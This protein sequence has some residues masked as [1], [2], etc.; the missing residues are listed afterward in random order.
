MTAT[1]EDE[2]EHSSYTFKQVVLEGPDNYNDWYRGITN[3]LLIRDLIDIAEGTEL[4]PLPEKGK[5]DDAAHL[6]RLKSFRKDDR[7]AYGLINASVST[8]VIRSVPSSIATYDPIGAIGWSHVLLAHLTS[9]YSSGNGPRQAEL[10]QLVF[11][12]ELDEGVDPTPFVSK[13]KGAFEDILGSGTDVPDHVLSYAILGSLPP[14]WS[15]LAQT[16]YMVEKPTSASV[17]AA[18]RTEWRRREGTAQ[19]ESALLVKAKKI[20]T[21]GANV[22][23]VNNAGSHFKDWPRDPNAYCE[24][25]K[26]NGHATKDCKGGKL[27]REKANTATTA[28]AP[29][30]GAQNAT[31]ARS[32]DNPAYEASGYLVH[33]SLIPT[34]LLARGAPNEFIVDSGATSH[35]TRD[36][37]NLTDIRPLSSPVTITV[38]NGDKITATEMGS[39]CLKDITLHNVLHVP[40]L[41]ANL[42]SV[43]AFEQ[44]PNTHWHFAGALAHLIKDGRKVI[45]A[46]LRG[47][48]YIV[49]PTCTLQSS[50]VAAVSD[51][52]LLQWHRRL[53]HLNPRDVVTLGKEGRLDDKVDWQVVEKDVNGFQC[54][55][56]VQGKGSRLPSPPSNIRANRPN[57]AIHVDLWGPAT[58]ASLGGCF[59]FLTCYDD[60]SRKIHLSFLKRKSDAAE[61]LITYIKLAE[62][63]LDLNVKTVRSDRGGEFEAG[64]LQDFFRDH[65]IEHHEVPPAAHAQNGRVERAHLTILNTVRTL[66]IES[67]LPDTFWAEAAQYTVYTRN[68]CPS[69]PTKQIP[70]DLWRGT[71]AATHHLQPFGCAVWFR[72][73]KCRNK[74]R[75]RYLPGRLVSYEEGTNNY[76]IWS[77]RDKKVIVT[78]D[79]TFERA[80][81]LIQAVT[82]PPPAPTIS[83]P[84]QNRYTV[85]EDPDDE[86]GRAREDEET[87]LHQ[88][89]EDT[90]TSGGL[91]IGPAP[92]SGPT[93]DYVTEDA[94][95]RGHQDRSV[96]VFEAL[97]GKRVTRSSRNTAVTQPSSP[98]ETAHFAHVSVAHA[99]VSSAIPQTFN[100]ARRAHDWDKWQSAMKSELEK[101]DKYHVWDTVPRGLAN[102]LLKAKWVYTRKIDGETGQPSTY[103]ARW[104]AKGYAQRAGIDFDELYAAVAHKDSVRVFLS[105]VNFHDYEC[106]QVD[107]VAAFLNGELQEQI[108]LEPPEGSPIPADRVLRLRKSL[109]GLKQSP[110]CFNKA[111][112]DWLRA[113]GFAPTR[114]DPCIYRRL[115]NGT[116]VLLSVHVDDQLIASNSRKDLDEFKKQLNARFECKDGGPV[117]YF[118]GFNVY[119]D[120]KARKLFVSQEHYVESVL[121]RFGMSDSS[122]A[123]QPLPSNFVSRPATD[124]EFAEAQSEEYPAMVGSI[125]YAATITRP[126][127]AYAAG[128]L[129]RTASKWN[130]THVHAARH[131]LRYLRATSDLCLTFDAIGG[132]R[133]ALGYADADWGGCLDTR[134]STTG[135]LFQTFG[136]PVAWKSR[137]QQT[138]AL[139]TAEAEYMAS[140]DAA[141]QALWL[142]RL[143]EDLHEP[144]TGPFPIL[145]D[146]NAC[147]QLSKNPVHHERSKHI[148]MRHHFLRDRVLDNSIVLSHVPSEDN[149]ADLF[150]KPLPADKFN[151][152]RRRLGVTR[153]V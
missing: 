114:A 43:S 9:T 94:P 128:L 111:L 140:A 77:D 75:P 17:L 100:E 109:Y 74:L 57:A 86:E 42:I 133:L 152:L 10:W 65:G 64:R 122:P 45:A 123:K 70:E 87:S 62:N 115:R 15:I 49:E 22:S 8:T 84:T 23:T 80:Q 31:S 127:I 113:Q 51:S 101:M 89:S 46:R 27:K 143:L 5:E 81:P 59:Y 95:R 82:V 150:T 102:R 78:R 13:I 142:R 96:E 61:A 99:L 6:A 30:E 90:A 108:F 44:V 21:E 33:T 151:D 141:R 16:I 121:D 53:G 37:S 7:K 32:S 36:R 153:R 79:V 131:L 112:D 68:R 125:M 116:I 52:M 134:R 118:L 149:L 85:L 54:S 69:G 105:L 19:R 66:L 124:D 138:T 28:P 136:G 25:H 76:R 38:G 129:A 98:E 47:G 55:V 63:Q 2:R 26:K 83:V 58:T 126:D 39:V 88:P 14:S 137:R 97:P 92:P 103:K 139:S 50:L 71:P 67:D 144:T 93:W 48:L 130:K 29:L 4:P 120:R 41:G 12:S 24:N 35:M 34:A 60:Y 73:H 147:I 1:T 104:V 20:S 148:D 40:D 11:R 110:R 146:N 72:D 132:Q 135:Y 107:I 145:N 119:R 56:C 117:S 91:P 106:D 18:I 3:T